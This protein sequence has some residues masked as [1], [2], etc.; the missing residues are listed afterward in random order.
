MRKIEDVFSHPALVVLVRNCDNY[1]HP[2]EAPGGDLNEKEHDMKVKGLSIL[3]LTALAVAVALPSVASASPETPRITTPAPG[4]TFTEDEPPVFELPFAAETNRNAA[5]WVVRDWRGNEVRRGEWPAD[6]R[7]EL[8]PLPPGFY[9]VES[10][11]ISRNSSLATSA[12]GPSFD[13][14]VVRRDPCRNPD[15]PFAVDSAL[16]HR[17]ETFDCPWHGGNTFRVVCELMRKCGVVQTRERMAWNG[18]N[19][20]PGIYTYGRRLDNV[21]HLRANGLVTTG[22]FAGT[23]GH[24]G[25]EEPGR[26]HLPTDL[27]ALY[28]LMTNAVP[29]FGDAYNAWGFWNE[30]DLSMVPEP[31]W[32]YVAA[33]KAFALAVR[34]A[35]PA[36]PVLLGALADVPDPDFGAGLVANEFQ[37]F[38][39]I[40]NIHTYLEP[41]RLPSWQ[42]G[43]RDFLAQCGRPGWAVWLTEFGTNLEGDAT[44]DG[45]RPGIKAHSREQ[46][47]IWAE[48]YPKGAIL[49]QMGGIDRSWLFLFG[50]YNERG[51]RK[52]WGTMRR[53]GHVKPICAALSALTG[54][55]GNAR[56]MGEVKVGNGIRAFLYEQP[57]DMEERQADGNLKA[58]CPPRQTLAFWSVSEID[59]AM[60]GPVHP[61]EALE[62][63]F[64]IAVFHPSSRA[65]DEAA[66]LADSLRL[67]DMMGMPRPAPIPSTDGALALMAERW[68]QYLTGQLGLAPDIPA[69]PPGR[70]IRYEAAHGEDL[71]IVV[72]P[73]LSADFEIVGHKS[74]AELV[75]AGG[76]SLTVELWNF[77]GEEKTGRL[78][79]GAG[80]GGQFASSRPAARASGEAAALADIL[81]PAWGHATVP[82]CYTPPADGPLETVLELRF[83]SDAGVSTAARVPVFDRARF[84][85]TCEVVPLALEDPARWRRNDSGQSF[86]CAY[87]EAE[88]AIRWEVGWTG[89]TGPWFMPWHDLR[90]PEESFAGAKMLE[91]EVKSEQD[92]VENDY[93][94]AVLM[95]TWADGHSL[96]LHY[97]PP[98]FNWEVRRVAL[99]PDAGGVVSIRL[100]GAPRGRRLTFWLR[101]VRILK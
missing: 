11:L 49:Q 27:M 75:A 59:T 69:P 61:K 60:Q 24:A 101:N 4:W 57:A 58:A 34:A 13:F 19:P 62:R 38:A 23:P 92:K 72:R 10:Q 35:D 64:Q 65:S 53:D 5:A 6:G 66:S 14:C 89:E 43:L 31:V 100:G 96:N 46:E 2:L 56:L 97:A 8:A 86:S 71:S 76:G 70:V 67:I 48:W 12:G 73:K 80:A 20:E 82:L 94:S 15:S 99:P 3:A 84:L 98:G 79:V 88:K 54:E 47:M 39:D 32:E 91:F 44:E 9:R 7:L 68:P 83:S 78:I 40:F 77:S 52:D 16:S 1:C 87:D 55:L 18:M 81:L 45:V 26:R 50:C 17:A 42:A 22:I 95:P 21:A 36:K 51:D 25:G 37:K 90:L 93:N 74:R 33:F 28:T 85:A 41:T 63:P 30:P 29:V